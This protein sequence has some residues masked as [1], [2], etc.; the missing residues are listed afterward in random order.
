MPNIYYCHPINGGSG[1]LR[2]VLSS[3]E[4][5]RLLS[6]HPVQY[7]GQQF[8]AATADQTDDCAVLRISDDELSKKWQDGFYRF[9]ADIKLIE[10]AVQTCTTNLSQVRPKSQTAVSLAY[11]SLVCGGEPREQDSNP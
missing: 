1:I 2:A 7:A 9:D 8:P 3:E 4:A 11:T 10:K 5:T 6:E